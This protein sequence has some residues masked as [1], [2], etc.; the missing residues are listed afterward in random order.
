MGGLIYGGGGGYTWTTFL[1][2]FA[3]FD[4]S[5]EIWKV[6]TVIT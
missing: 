2:W 1:G 5:L 3:S 6:T 4:K